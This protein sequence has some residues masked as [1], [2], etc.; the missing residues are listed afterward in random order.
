VLQ[1]ANRHRS[2]ASKHNTGFGS[3]YDFRMSPD[4]S[5]SKISPRS[6]AAHTRSSIHSP[7]ACE[8]VSTRQSTGNFF[9]SSG[10]GFFFFLRVAI[11][12]RGYM[13]ARG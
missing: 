3:L 11:G 2:S 7:T 4:F 6:F 1:P 8:P 9:N 10:C 5:I 12:A 13:T